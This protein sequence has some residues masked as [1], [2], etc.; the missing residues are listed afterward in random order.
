MGPARFLPLWLRSRLQ[1]LSETRFSALV[2]GLSN[3][4]GFRQLVPELFRHSD[5]ELFVG[6]VDRY[7]LLF[8]FFLL[9]VSL[10]ALA[11]LRWRQARAPGSPAALSLLCMARLVV[12]V[13]GVGSP[14]NPAEELAAQLQE[15]VFFLVWSLFLGTV[16]ASFLLWDHLFKVGVVLGGLSGWWSVRRCTSGRSACGPANPEVRA[17]LP[18]GQPDHLESLAL[19]NSVGDLCSS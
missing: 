6:Q 13:Y 10:S 17:Q 8:V 9:S 16:Q 14:P 19:L 11:Q 12:C 1:W 2:L 18:T 4:L 3:Q 15:N 5:V 7:Q